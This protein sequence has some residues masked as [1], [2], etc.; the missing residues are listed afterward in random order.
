[1]TSPSSSANNMAKQEH[2]KVQ[3][4]VVRS[5]ERLPPWMKQYLS[6]HKDKRRITVHS[7]YVTNDT[8]I[9]DNT[10]YLIVRCLKKEVCGR[11]TDRLK[12]IPF[13]LMV[14]NL[15]NRVR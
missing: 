14:A 15:T 11:L 5:I 9:D 7:N 8:S 6:W 3:S 12:P 13:Y 1:M 4:K 10:K 2:E